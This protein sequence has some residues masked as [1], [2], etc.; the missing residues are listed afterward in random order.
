M[1]WTGGVDRAGRAGRQARRHPKLPVLML[2]PVLAGAVFSSAGLRAETQAQLT[3]PGL[4]AAAE[5]V[6]DGSTPAS[7][8]AR[9]GG[10]GVHVI[11]QGDSLWILANRFRPRDVSVQQMMLALHRANPGAFLNEDIN[12]LRL[13]AALNIPDRAEILRLNAPD[14]PSQES[15]REDAVPDGQG[16]DI[17]PPVIAAIPASEPESRPVDEPVPDVSAPVVAAASEAVAPASP[18]GEAE[19]AAGSESIT[20]LA[21]PEPEAAPE[22]PADVS[23]AQEVERLRQQLM[24]MEAQ[25]QQQA[26]SLDATRRELVE[27]QRQAELLARDVQPVS[28]PEQAVAG[29]VARPA[30]VPVPGSVD[31]AAPSKPQSITLPLDTADTDAPAQG[32]DESRGGGLPASVLVGLALLVVLLVGIPIRLWN[33][34]RLR[35][36]ARQL[37]ELK[38]AASEMPKEP[39]LDLATQLDTMLDLCEAFIAMR[40]YDRARSSL[41]AVLEQGSEKQKVRAQ[42]LLEQVP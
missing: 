38:Q 13:G 11:R 15:V 21:S 30:T 33:R 23:R 35:R 14:A 9:T 20:R 34:Y 17:P 12:S 36:L 32:S 31:T 37:E 41:A 10:V 39:K 8:L 25:L 29:T 4:P 26:Q 18:A 7:R 5:V 22:G 16:M 42:T 1:R 27:L 6:G 19:A 3:P 24:E 40:D 28:A 2:M